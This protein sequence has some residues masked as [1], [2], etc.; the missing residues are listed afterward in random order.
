MTFQQVLGLA[1]G[2]LLITLIAFAFRQGMKVK[3]SGKAHPGERFPIAGGDS[4]SGPGDGWAHQLLNFRTASFVT[5][6]RPLVLRG[7]SIRSN[8]QGPPTATIQCSVKMAASRHSRRFLRVQA[9]RLPS[10]TQRESRP[11]DRQ[12]WAKEDS[13]SGP[14][15]RAVFCL[16]A[17]SAPSRRANQ[18]QRTQSASSN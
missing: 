1:G 4:Y 5:P 10:D 9:V 17:V 8:R 11:A 12:P 7:P 18:I 6:L 13:Q 16:T 2:V 15:Q 14:A 3:P